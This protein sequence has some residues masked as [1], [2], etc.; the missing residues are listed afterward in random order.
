MKQYS[1]LSSDAHEV[2]LNQAMAEH[3]KLVGWVVRR[4]W[5]GGLPYADMLQEG[6][7]GLWRA[8]QGYDPER[9]TAFSTYAVP[10]IAR[11]VWRAVSLAQRKPPEQLTPHPPQEAPDLEEHVERVISY[12]L[13]YGL[14]A[15][16]PRRRWRAV[17][18][19]HYG[20]DGRP[21]QTLSEIARAWGVT[22]QRIFQLRTEALLWLAHPARSGALRQLLGCNTVADYQAYLARQR[23]WQRMKRGR[24]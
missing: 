21:A 14:V 6:R 3:E 11:A 17:I 5:S 9:G 7:V 1:V 19:T 12:E 16:L 4:Q 22:P 2:G 20:L 8:L 13:L 24:R 10:A 18:V 15:A 23:R